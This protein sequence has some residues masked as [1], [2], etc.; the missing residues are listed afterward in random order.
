MQLIFFIAFV[1]LFLK[2]NSTDFT[3]LNKCASHYRVCENLYNI[4]CG[5]GGALSKEI[6]DVPSF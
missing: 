6:A 2:G 4:Y 5:C 1:D 3:Y